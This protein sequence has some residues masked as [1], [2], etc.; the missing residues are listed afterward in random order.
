VYQNIILTQRGYYILL[1]CSEFN[2]ARPLSLPATPKPFSRNY[3][4][5]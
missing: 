2:A 3:L 1:G 4:T 5:F